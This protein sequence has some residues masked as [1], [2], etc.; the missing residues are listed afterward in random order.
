M[1]IKKFFTIEMPNSKVV[2]VECGFKES[3]FNG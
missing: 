1:E 2:F 3:D